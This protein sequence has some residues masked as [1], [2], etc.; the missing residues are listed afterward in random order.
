M[1]VGWLVAC[2]LVC[3]Y[4]VQSTEQSIADTKAF[5]QYVDEKIADPRVSAVVTPRFVPSCS[6]PLMRELGELAKA[7]KAPIQSHLS[8][9]VA[10]VCA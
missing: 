8:E 4:L 9:S 3:R 10:E 6:S 5:F 1:A 7:A 2:L